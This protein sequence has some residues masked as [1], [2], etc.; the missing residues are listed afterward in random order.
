MART[1]GS[2][3]G[4]GVIIAVGLFIWFVTTFFWWIVAAAG[5]VAVYAIV[6]AVMRSR[7]EHRAAWADYHA[8][9]AAR[10]DQQ[11]AWVQRGDDRGIF[12]P[13]GA[14]VMRSVFP[15]GLLGVSREILGDRDARGRGVADR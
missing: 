5:A 7:A 13:E 10:A 11:H 15:E 6:R 8:L 12:G 14:D 1:G 4:W 3:D 9:L 2:S